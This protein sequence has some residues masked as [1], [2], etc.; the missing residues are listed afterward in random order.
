MRTQVCSC[1]NM[2]LLPSILAKEFHL[3]EVSLLLWSD[4]P[5]ALSACRDMVIASGSDWASSASESSIPFL[6]GPD[7]GSV[8]YVMN[9]SGSKNGPCKVSL[10]LAMMILTYFACLVVAKIVAAIMFRCFASELESPST[11]SKTTRSYVTADL[12]TYCHGTKLWNHDAFSWATGP[13]QHF[14]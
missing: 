3:L 10:T 7:N 11:C 12:R 14:I 9:W 8:N 1:I 13:A 5:K 6:C 2:L 4:V